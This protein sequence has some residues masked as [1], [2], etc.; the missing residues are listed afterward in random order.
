[1]SVFM[2]KLFCFLLVA[3]ALFVV[4]KSLYVVFQRM[5]SYDRRRVLLHRF[6]QRKSI[7][8]GQEILDACHQESSKYGNYDGSYPKER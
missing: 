2:L 3:F 8:E 7:A 6:I 4:L 1:M 5:R